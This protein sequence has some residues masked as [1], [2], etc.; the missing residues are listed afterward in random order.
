MKTE[1]HTHRGAQPSVLPCWLLQTLCISLYHILVRQSTSLSL[2]ISQMKCASVCLLTC[3]HTVSWVWIRGRKGG[4]G[5]ND[6]MIRHPSC[7]LVSHKYMPESRSQKNTATKSSW[8]EWEAA[9][10]TLFAAV[11][12][13]LLHSNSAL[14]TLK[15][16]TFAEGSKQQWWIAELCSD[17]FIMASQSNADALWSEKPYG[18][19]CLF[20]CRHCRLVCLNSRLCSRESYTQVRLH[21]FMF[22]SAPM[23]PHYVASYWPGMQ[24][25]LWVVYLNVSMQRKELS[26][27]SRSCLRPRLDRSH[28]SRACSWQCNDNLGMSWNK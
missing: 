19:A 3:T 18:Y 8:S 25:A 9:P 12:P 17:K 15:P 16:Q 21:L 1:T 22:W 27:F 13:F 28:Q 4:Q 6:W 5:E 10:F 26:V 14:V 24:S 20:Y 23:V 11:R 7:S 2:P